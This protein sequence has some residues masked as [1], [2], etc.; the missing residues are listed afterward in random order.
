MCRGWGSGPGVARMVQDLGWALGLE[1]EWAPV[2]APG[3]AVGCFLV[4]ESV[5]GVGPLLWV[6]GWTL[7]SCSG[8]VWWGGA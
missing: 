3:W 1:S 7:G 8:R 6:K 5:G 4:L 2:L